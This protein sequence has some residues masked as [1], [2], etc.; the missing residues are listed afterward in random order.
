MTYAD[1]ITIDALEHDP[2]PVYARLRRE[3]PLVLVPAANCWFATRWHDIDAINRSPDFTAASDD[4]PVNSA[5]GRPN[6]LTSDGAVHSELRTG[7]DAHYKPRKVADYIEALVRPIAESQLAAFRA[8]DDNDLMALYFEPISALSLARS[9]GLTDVDVATLRRWFHGLSQGAINFERDPAR[10][11]ICA[12][13][14]A[15]IEAVLLPFLARLAK[16]PDGS[17]LSHLLHAGMLDG[18]TRAPERILPTVKVTLLGG[19]Q[20]P[21][22]GAASTLAGLLAN[23]DQLQALR[24]NLDALLPIAIDEG[25]RWIAPIGTMMRTALCD[26]VVNGIDVP[27]GT[28][29]SL[30]MASANRDE[31]RFPHP[32]AFNIHRP[33][34][35]HMSFG[36]GAH[37]CAGKWFAKAQIDIALRVLLD[38]Y[39]DMQLAGPPPEFRG[40]EF[41][42]PTSLRVVK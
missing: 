40:W 33:Q 36:A 7:I 14:V 24:Q 42:A 22:H 25:L 3:E 2:Y 8:S 21:G 6:V 32:D 15:H 17:P 1:T 16:H 38:A 13:A 29:I 20:E 10:A 35:S 12:D 28:A 30:I 5:F 39:P 41:R 11:A 4:A 19:M 23:P 37:F 26:T 34:T 9:F 27:K 31:A 18:E